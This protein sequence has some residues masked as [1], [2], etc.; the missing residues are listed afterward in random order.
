MF[1]FPLSIPEDRRI[2]ITQVF[3]STALV[4]YYKSKGLNIQEHMAV[5]VTCGNSAQT[6][7]TPFVCPFPTAT[8]NTYTQADPEN[9]MGGRIIV[10]YTQPDGTVLYVGG[11]HLSGVNVQK[12]YKEGDVL[13]WIGNYGY[14]LPEPTIGTPFGGSHIH[15][16]L[17]EKK[18]GQAN[19][20]TVDPLLY[21]DVKNPFRSPDTGLTRD[22]FAF[23]WAI[24]KIKEA[25][26]KLKGIA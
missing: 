18:P 26:K 20:T 2:E 3:K 11:I 21:F 7:G 10:Q 16:T 12:I 9:G 8:I 14:V 6:Y 22:V 5:D 1:K 24:Q 25:I 19:G 15:L 13:G 23:K 17:V 4:E